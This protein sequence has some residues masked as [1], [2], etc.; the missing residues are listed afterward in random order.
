MAIVL[1]GPDENTQGYW[2][3]AWTMVS[4][5]CLTPFD[6]H[7]SDEGQS[8]TTRLRGNHRRNV[9][10]FVSIRFAVGRKGTLIM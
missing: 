6:A 4:I 1:P 8:G 5:F 9:A 7:Y 10:V 2:P 3:G